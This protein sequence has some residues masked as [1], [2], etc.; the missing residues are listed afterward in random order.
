MQSFSTK[1][2]GD[3]LIVSFLKSTIDDEG[4][5][6][7]VGRELLRVATKAA[8]QKMLLDFQNVEFMAS[9]MIGQLFVLHGMCRASKIR[10]MMCGVHGLVQK[11]LGIVRL[12]DFIETVDD[13]AAA[14]ERFAQPLDP[15]GFIENG[16]RVDALRVRADAG[17]TEA[18]F[19]LA[20]C[21]ENG[22]GVPCDFAQALRWFQSA[23]AADHA[24]SQ[25][26]VGLAFAYGIHVQQ[27]YDQAVDWYR[28]SAEQGNANAQYALGMSYDYGIALPEDKLA[29]I[30]WYRKAAEQ[31]HKNAIDELKRA[32]AK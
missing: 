27:D 32:S 9:S 24:E 7:D 18:Q 12:D 22:E 31:G 2:D 16:T 28:Q 20:L 21:Y 11:I 15:E 10:L 26:R 1:T 25:Y 29:A 4:V 17:D 14:R 19:E 5:I 30:S 8:P 6:H 3:I 23:A 13:V